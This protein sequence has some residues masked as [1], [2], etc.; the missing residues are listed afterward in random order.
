MN[1]I[2]QHVPTF[3]DDRGPLKS[4]EFE[5]ITELLAIP[6]VAQW[7]ETMNGQPFHQFSKVDHHLMA[8]HAE[9]HTWWVVGYITDPGS[10][11]LPTWHAKAKRG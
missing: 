3:V 5:T 1:S 7:A 4:A 11:E 6:W 2:T 10:V 9:G 8:E